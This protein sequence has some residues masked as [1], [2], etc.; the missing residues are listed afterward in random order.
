MQVWDRD[1]SKIMSL[2]DGMQKMSKSDQS[3]Y[4]RINLKDDKDT[5]IKKIKYI[6][7]GNLWL[8]RHYS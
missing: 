6:I 1:I 3:D 8:L 4:S 7:F 2:R 5:I